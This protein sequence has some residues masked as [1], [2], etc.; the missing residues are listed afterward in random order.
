MPTYKYSALNE[1]GRTIR[2]Q[3]SADNEIDLESR[4]KEI[5]LD[6]IDFKEV[7]QKKAGFGAK[8]KQRDII[9]M[10]LHMEQLNRA[11]VTAY[12]ALMDV[13][14]STESPKLRDIVADMCERVKG[15]APLSEA[16]AHHEKVFGNVFVGLLKAG[17]ASGNLTQ[18]FEHMSNHA[19][20]SAELKRRIKKAIAYPLVLLVIMTLVII[21][22]MLAVVPKLIDFMTSQ[23]F[24][25]PLHTR[26]LIAT[27]DFVQGYWWVI[28]LTPI[29]TFVT[30]KLMYRILPGF[31]YRMD[32]LFMRLPV[33]GNAIRKINLARFTHFFGVLFRSGI[34]ILDALE[35][36]R[37]VVTN[38]VLK[39]SIGVV[40]KSVT[41]GNS[42]TASL[43]ISGEFPNL[44]VRMFKVG[45]DSGN[46]N[47]ALENVTY[48]YNREVD[49][50]VDAIVGSI[51]PV[52]TGVMGGLIFWII[53]AVFGPLYGSFKDMNF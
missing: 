51:Q 48:F 35:A 37:D 34:D 52:L 30:F 31:A 15:G 14:D 19:K 41:E 22:L 20:W 23:G 28:I 39:E 3:I 40:I 32:W 24:D 4:L 53:A 13:R 5:D 46:M 11:G 43:R 8:V 16:M 33:I 7:V 44:V 27:S 2:G 18:S 38:K 6:L 10:C 49:D 50:A 45:E 25:L 9:M 36:S 21:V 26:A 12:D 17:E 42:L 47:E 1:M 29:V